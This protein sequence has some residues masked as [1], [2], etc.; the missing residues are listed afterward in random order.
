MSKDSLLAPELG[1]SFT[2]APIGAVS[3]ATSYIF[4]CRNHKDKDD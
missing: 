1:T 2:K 3:R 4:T